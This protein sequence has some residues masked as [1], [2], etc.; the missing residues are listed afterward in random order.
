MYG[1]Y[2][3]LGCAG[4]E[5]GRAGLGGRNGLAGWNGRTGVLF[6]L[7]PACLPA[8]FSSALDCAFVR[9]AEE[10]VRL[11]RSAWRA[12]FDWLYCVVMCK[13]TMTLRG[14]DG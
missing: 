9:Q 12:I 8:S 6:G 11:R 5:G 7:L 14:V 3:W 1:W 13:I 10:G 2:G 4:K